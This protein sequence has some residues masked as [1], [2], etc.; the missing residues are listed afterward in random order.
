[1]V[2]KS[3]VDRWLA[4]IVV[5][6]SFVPIPVIAELADS[7]KF[8]I[9]DVLLVTPL[10]ALVTVV[11]VWAFLSTFYVLTEDALLVRSGPF[12][13]NIPYSSIRS[14]SP[15]RALLSGPALSLDRLEV[16]YGGYDVLYVSPER[17]KEF[18]TALHLRSPQ[19]RIA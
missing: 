2:F 13:W 16:V 19:A 8:G 5:G 18:L 14:V 11:V 9:R 12:R 17:S 4:V 10:V 3:K 7:G 1:M 15:S 6:A